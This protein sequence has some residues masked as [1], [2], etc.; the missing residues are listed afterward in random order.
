MNGWRTGTRKGSII[1][2]KPLSAA[3]GKRGR[4]WRDINVGFKKLFQYC[5]ITPWVLKT[6]N[7]PRNVS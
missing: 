5:V 7:I 3:R 4:N 2:E 6:I 1:V